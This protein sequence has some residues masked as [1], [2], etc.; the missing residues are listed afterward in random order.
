MRRETEISYTEIPGPAP[1]AGTSCDAYVE[2]SL[3][4]YVCT[5]K[6]CTTWIQCP[7]TRMAFIQLCK[8]KEA[9]FM[10][11]VNDCKDIFCGQ[12]QHDW[13][14]DTRESGQVTYPDGKFEWTMDPSIGCK[15]W[16]KVGMKDWPQVPLLEPIPIRWKNYKLFGFAGTREFKTYT[17]AQ[18]V[19]CGGGDRKCTWFIIDRVPWTISWAGWVPGWA[20]KCPHIACKDWKLFIKAE[21]AEETEYAPCK[22]LEILDELCNSPV[23]NDLTKQFT[24]IQDCDPDAAIEQIQKA[25]E[26]E[27]MRRRR[28]GLLEA[29]GLLEPQVVPAEFLDF[30]LA[31]FQPKVQLGQVALPIADIIR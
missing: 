7:A 12:Q 31:N 18:C 28:G 17:V 23:C 29:A 26:E 13:L 27:K 22:R 4:V 11:A 15:R 21:I 30:D 19:S 16:T 3:T 6:D 1:Q 24:S 14:L 20:S 8:R 9:Y 2:F 25:Y 5:P 10:Q